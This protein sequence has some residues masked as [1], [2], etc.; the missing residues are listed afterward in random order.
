MGSS[1]FLTD[2]PAQV[3][4]DPTEQ[5]TNISTLEDFQWKNEQGQ[6]SSDWGNFK[7]VTEQQ[8]KNKESTGK[9]PTVLIDKSCLYNVSGDMKCGIN[10]KYEPAPIVTEP[11]RPQWWVPQYENQHLILPAST[12]E[13]VFGYTERFDEN[14]CVP[15]HSKRNLFMPN[16]YQDVKP[17]CNSKNVVGA[18]EWSAKGHEG[19]GF[20]PKT[21]EGFVDNSREEELSFWQGSKAAGCSGTYPKNDVKMPEYVEQKVAWKPPKEYPDWYHGCQNDKFAKNIPEP[22]YNKEGPL[23]KVK[24][25]RRFEERGKDSYQT[26]PPADRG[27][28]SCKSDTMSYSDNNKWEK[29]VA[30]QPV[31]PR[32]D[33][34]KFFHNL[35]ADENK[36]VIPSTE[37]ENKD[38]EKHASVSYPL[39]R[40]INHVDRTRMN[41]DYNYVHGASE[42][43]EIAKESPGKEKYVTPH[44]HSDDDLYN[45]WAPKHVPLYAEAKAELATTKSNIENFV[46]KRVDAEKTFETSYS[47]PTEGKK[48][49]TI[50]PGAYE[51]EG[52]GWEKDSLHETFEPGFID[53]STNKFYWVDDVKD[54]DEMEDKMKE[55]HGTFE[56]FD[57][58]KVTWAE[59]KNK[60]RRKVFDEG[61][62]KK[63]RHMK[64]KMEG[65]ERFV[66][67]PEGMDVTQE[68]MQGWCEKIMREGTEAKKT[69]HKFF[70]W[71][72]YS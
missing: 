7:D 27:I 8:L 55:K 71:F 45:D 61:Y 28:S 33:Y 49:D 6:S 66:V 50:L 38:K 46:G 39:R 60:M 40:K 43:Q 1:W 20:V 58:R 2:E 48:N 54:A 56:N 37:W 21:I 5:P 62:R 35:Y 70:D 23:D 15:P 69:V 68:K 72:F 10:E 52:A 32:K 53:E 41:Y 9:V 44:I 67:L 59:D 3:S 26:A 34:N 13:S 47:Y 31:A 4:D 17:S 57:V 63:R 22:K 65:V 14:G 11:V 51:F 25:A 16:W 18:Y 19:H 64:V 42:T 30:S 24:P 36:Y 29:S 12:N